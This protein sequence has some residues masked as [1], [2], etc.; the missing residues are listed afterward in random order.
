M[1][2]ENEE[3]AKKKHQCNLKVS[4]AIWAIVTAVLVCLLILTYICKTNGEKQ[5]EDLKDQVS[6]K[7]SAVEDE[8]EPANPSTS[9]TLDVMKY[10]AIDENVMF[11]RPSNEKEIIEK[12]EYYNGWP[13]AAPGFG[14]EFVGEGLE[15]R[16]MIISYKGKKGTASWDCESENAKA[17]K[18]VKCLTIGDYYYEAIYTD[19]L[20]DAVKNYFLDEKN[21]EAIK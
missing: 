21:Y 12:Y 9:K 20:S 2:K 14:I 8:I 6:K 18:G 10:M 5:I 17:Q 3:K 11:N 1:E 16:H 19:N 7:C 13:Q 15:D 4:T